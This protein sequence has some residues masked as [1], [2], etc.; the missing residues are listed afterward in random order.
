M[1]ACPRLRARWPKL[2]IPFDGFYDFEAIQ[3][4]SQLV[5]VVSCTDRHD[6]PRYA[7]PKATDIIQLKKLLLAS[8]NMEVFDMASSHGEDVNADWNIRDWEKLPAFKDL[9]LFNI[10]WNFSQVEAVTFWDWSRITRL[11]M[12]GVNIIHF[13]R[14]VP[15]ECLSGLHTFETDCWGSDKGVEE[16]SRLLCN[17]VNTITA[18]ESLQMQCNMRSH[19]NRCFPAIIDYGRSLRSLRLRD[20][21]RPNGNPNIYSVLSIK[22][23]EALGSACPILRELAID[24]KLTLDACQKMRSVLAITLASF[25]NLRK[26]DLH[27]FMSFPRPGT[28]FDS[29]EIDIITPMF[30]WMKDLVSMKQGLEFDTVSLL[31]ETNRTTNDPGWHECFPIYKAIPV[32]KRDESSTWAIVRVRLSSWDAS[33]D[34]A[35]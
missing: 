11:R 7:D 24:V 30:P 19:I 3:F 27:T 14:T 23:L 31:V 16:A 15:P 17:L 22:K 2:R 20:F 8:P 18:L 9:E 25:R 4:Y 34:N 1:L 28:D 35:S 26:L 33:A 21:R 6:D 32:N 29:W 5:D 13:L 12:K 10:R